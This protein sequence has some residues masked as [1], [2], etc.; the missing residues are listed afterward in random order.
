MTGTQVG[1]NHY[2]ECAI[3]PIDFITANGLDFMQGNV[4]K[5]ITRHKRKDKDKDIKKAIQYCTFI[6]KYDYG[7]SDEKVKDFVLGLFNEVKVG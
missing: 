2:S 5:Y 1:G 3:Q 4:V 7:F 6:L